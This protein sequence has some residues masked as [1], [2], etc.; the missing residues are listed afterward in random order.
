[1]NKSIN[2]EEENDLM[3]VNT[4][5]LH[6]Y[7]TC[8]FFLTLKNMSNHNGSCCFVLFFFKIILRSLNIQMRLVYFIENK[9]NSGQMYAVYR[10]KS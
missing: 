1:M 9:D 5:L 3:S 7:V 6:K 2:L 8:G 4:C 10:A